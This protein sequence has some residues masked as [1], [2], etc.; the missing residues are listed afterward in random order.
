[1]K[2]VAF[3]ISKNTTLL[4]YSKDDYDRSQ[5]DSVLYLKCYNRI[6]INEWKKIKQDLFNF[7][8][9]EMVVHKDSAI[10]FSSRF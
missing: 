2:T 5:I 10:N 3:D 9:Q 6:S 7:K 4:T 1:M 8:T